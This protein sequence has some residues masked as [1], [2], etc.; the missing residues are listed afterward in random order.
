MDSV[1]TCKHPPMI[2]IT[3]HIQKENPITVLLFI[4]NLQ[5]LFGDFL[6]FFHQV[7]DSF[8]I[9]WTDAF[10]ALRY[11]KLFECKVLFLVYFL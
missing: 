4:Q 1:L 8:K 3:L 6:Q 9:L 2:P 7:L 11:K 10:F 5:K